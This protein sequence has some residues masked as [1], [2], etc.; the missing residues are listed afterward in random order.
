MRTHT[1]ERRLR[2]YRAA[3]RVEGERVRNG[4]RRP[5]L[6]HTT[7]RGSVTPKIELGFCELCDSP[8]GYGWCGPNGERPTMVLCNA[9]R[10]CNPPKY[11]RRAMTEQEL[12]YHRAGEA[13]TARLVKA[14]SRVPHTL[15][16]AATE[17][18]WHELAAR[19]EAADV[20]SGER[21]A[22]RDSVAESAQRAEAE[23]RKHLDI[24]ERAVVAACRWGDVAR[25]IW[26]EY[27]ELGA[28]D[29]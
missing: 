5:R 28:R 6:A 1:L 12:L 11:R 2:G 27:H 22:T 10:G 25:N 17:A 8:Y 14:E 24:A 13:E 9:C 29:K 4:T 7:V 18:F 21:D 26:R 15:P 20:R 3:C 23:M 16:D 19:E